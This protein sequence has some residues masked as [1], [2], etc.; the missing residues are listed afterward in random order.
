MKE[1]QL[2]KIAE[3]HLSYSHKKALALVG[4][5]VRDGNNGLA[6]QTTLMNGAAIAAS[7]NG[8]EKQR[9]MDGCS[10]I[11]DAYQGFAAKLD[12]LIPDEDKS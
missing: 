8:M 12:A 4:D 1:E 11:Y 10:K 5:L 3:E 6:I 9:F 7:I 2:K